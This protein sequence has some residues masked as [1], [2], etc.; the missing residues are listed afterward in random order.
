MAGISFAVLKRVCLMCTGLYAVNAGLLVL[1]VAHVARRAGRPQALRAAVVPLVLA[2]AVGYTTTRLGTRG[3]EVHTL[4]DLRT[5]EPKFYRWY[6]AL[7]VNAAATDLSAQHLHMKGPVGAPVMI[8]EYSDFS[9]AHCARAYRDLSRLLAR[10]PNDVR[11]VFRHFPLDASCNPTMKDSLHPTACTAAMAAECAGEVGKFWEFHD[12]LFEHRGPHDYGQ[13]ATSL[14]LDS[15]RFQSCMDSGRGRAAVVR[16][17][18]D[19]RKLGVDSTP[20]L[21]INGRTVRGALD[22]RLYEF[23]LLIEKDESNHRGGR[24]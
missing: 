12:Y 13:V 15:K 24:P 17:I 6:R 2:L 10:R 23:V 16:D 19:S 5:R 9:C 4:E 3:S 11:L 8:V 20:T 22:D 1:S 18:D 7:P 21:F 14:G